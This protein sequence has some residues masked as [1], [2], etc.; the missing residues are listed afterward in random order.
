MAGLGEEPGILV[1][2]TAPGVVVT[3][4]FDEE[5]PEDNKPFIILLRSLCFNDTPVPTLAV[6]PV[7]ISN[8]EREP[9]GVEAYATITRVAIVEGELRADF[10]T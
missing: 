8:R 7:V 9:H 2:G 1:P 5:N 4:T 3:V 6:V 10:Y